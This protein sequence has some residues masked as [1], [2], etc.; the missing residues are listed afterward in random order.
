MKQLNR[1]GLIFDH[2]KV[3][4]KERGGLHFK[5]VLNS[6]ELE[7]LRKSGFTFKVTIPDVVQNYLNRQK[8]LSAQAACQQEPIL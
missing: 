7:I 5:A 4:D 3:L 1:M 8:E 6:S 2:I